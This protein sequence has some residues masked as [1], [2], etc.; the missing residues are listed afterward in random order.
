M[1]GPQAHSCFTYSDA[2]RGDHCG[3]H[4]PTVCVQPRRYGK[5]Q[6]TSPQPDYKS[7]SLASLFIC[8]V[9]GIFAYRAS[10]RVVKF[11]KMKAYEQAAHYSEAALKYNRSAVACAVLMLLIIGVPL[12][13][14]LI[15][16]GLPSKFPSAHQYFG[17]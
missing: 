6:I 12:L 11:N 8:F 13:I 16:Q 14:A 9:W 17:R 3:E 4:A 2:E 7:W 5:M 15:A 10:N 1:S